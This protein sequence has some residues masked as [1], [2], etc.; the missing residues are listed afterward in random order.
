MENTEITK[1]DVGGQA[2]ARYKDL[3]YEVWFALAEFIDNSLHA[4]LIQPN[5]GESLCQVVISHN[6]DELNIF[7]NAG[8]IPV[9]QFNRLLSIGQ[10]KDTA[11]KQ[12]SK[13]GMGMKTAGIWLA[14]SLVIE[15]KYLDST[16]CYSISIDIGELRLG[17]EQ[18]V[19]IE[20]CVP[21]SS[22]SGY[23]K[24][25]LSK[26]HRNI[27]RRTLSKTKESIGSIYKRYIEQ[28]LLE[29]KWNDESIIPLHLELMHDAN[30]I[31][32]MDFS[33]EIVD[34]NTGEKKNAYGWVGELAV[35]NG[36]KA[37]F[38]VYQH[39]RQIHGYPDNTYKPSTIFGNERGS[40]TLVNQRLIGEINME[41]FDVAHTKNKILF[42]GNDKELFEEELRKKCNTIIKL[43]QQTGN[44]S[45]NAKE[46]EQSSSISA[47]KSE[48]TD[49]M[50]N[51]SSLNISPYKIVKQFAQEE[52]KKII[53]SPID[54]N[55]I[56]WIDQSIK[57]DNLE[58]EIDIFNITSD[59]MF[60]MQTNFRLDTQ[61]LEI[62]INQRHT[63][64]SY[65]MA[66]S[67]SDYTDFVINCIID[68]II[69]HLSDS[70]TTTED[71][72]W[73]KSCLLKNFE[74]WR[75]NG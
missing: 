45:K 27:T 55:K 58:F 64:V 5:R 22:L 73:T 43:A 12:L 68:G 3:D 32:R 8:G 37:G 17:N 42:T 67:T 59:N 36:A 66:K 21:S 9:D 46:N 38:Y 44:R 28:G 1:I 54:D 16:E 23:T 52:S 7:D 18:Y 69:E 6:E 19:T 75:R 26:L 71:R 39:D 15:T 49:W 63:Y 20:K 4:F 70:N 62:Y 13:F 24:I 50:S 35:G 47:S 60:Y 2:L 29:V 10:K 33:I 30:G 74:Q 57:M 25:T 56:K 65:I 53:D 51:N 11:E 72:F 34:I 61:I 41:D 40:N 48:I 14:D 31:R